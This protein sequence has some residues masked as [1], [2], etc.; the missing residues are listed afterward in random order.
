MD[1]K[2][3]VTMMT[4]HPDN[5]YDY[6]SIQEEPKEALAAL[7]PRTQ[8][9][10]GIQEIMIDFEGKLTPYHQTSQI[11]LGLIDQGLVPGRDVFVTPR[12]PNDRKETLFRQLMSVMSLVET[13]IQAAEKTDIQAISQAVVPMIESGEE[14]FRIEERIDSVIEMGNKNYQTNYAPGSIRVIPLVESVPALVNID[15]IIDEY[16]SACRLHK[17]NC[18][19][20]R[21]M[22]ARSDSG[23]SYGMVPSLLAVLVAISRAYAYGEQEGLTIDPILGGGSLPFRGHVTEENLQTF[24]DTFAGVRTVTIQ[25]GLRYDQ[26]PSSVHAVCAYL[27]KEIP[28]RKPRHFNK[29][30]VTFMLECMGIFSKYY[31]Q[32]FVHLMPSLDRITP[33]IP[34]NRDRLAT[35]KS[36][37]SYSREMVDVEQMASMVEDPDLKAAIRSIDTKLTCAIPRAI[38]FTASLYTIG[39]PPEL[40]GTGRGLDEVHK[41]YGPSGIDRLV[42][43]CPQLASDIEVSLRYVNLE[44]SKGLVPE[45]VRRDYA[46]DLGLV[47]RWMGTTNQEKDPNLNMYHALLTSS[48]PILGHLLDASKNMGLDEQEERIALEGRIRKMGHIRGSLG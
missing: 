47:N 46:Q 23:M 22:F 39:M 9:G 40:L 18:D 4:Q 6:I 14:I 2:I 20:M 16:V 15:R 36:G 27:E 21:L 8:N 10:L 29:E 30:E 42:T 48:M 26:G 43:I 45:S 24:C 32:T 44:A 17:K 31:L 28:K 25:S 19:H 38:S 34:K 35:T 7:R 3:P 33:F 5:A 11:T 1:R 13:N 41:R 37:V 12:I